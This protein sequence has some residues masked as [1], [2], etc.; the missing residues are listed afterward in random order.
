MLGRWG[1]PALRVRLPRARALTDARAG[2]AALGL[3]VTAVLAV[4]VFA[5]PRAAARSCPNSDHGFPAW[6]A[7]PLHLLVGGLRIAYNPLDIIFSALVVLMLPLYGVVVAAVRSLSL[8][9][10]AYTVV[11]LHLILLLSAP[12]QLNDV[13]NYL[14]YAR[15]GAV[16]G[17]NPY[18]H[19]IATI[20]HDP[21]YR[22]S[23]WHHLRSPYGWL[24]SAVTYPIALLPIPVA[25]WVLKVLAVGL[26]LVFVWLV[27]RCARLL[28][29]DP[30]FAVVLVA[31]NPIYLIYAVGGFHN[32][33]F[34]LVPMMAA[35][36]LMLERRDRSAGAML[37]LAVAVKFT[38]VLVLPFLLLGARPTRR[39][40]Q[41]L[42]GA[43][44]AAVPIARAHPGAVRAAPA[45]PP[46][47]EHAADQLQR[48]ERRRP[49][50]RRRW[51]GAVAAARGQRRG[52][53]RGRGAAAPP[54][55]LAHRRRVGDGG[56]DRQPGVADAVVRGVGAAAR[57]AA[58][59]RPAAPH[60]C[61]LHRVPRADVR[62]G[63][64]ACSRAASIQ[65]DGQ[66]RR[67][68]IA[69]PAGQARRVVRRAA[70]RF[71]AACHG[72]TLDRHREPRGVSTRSSSACCSPSGCCRCGWWRSICS[73]SWCTT[74]CGPAPTASTSSTRCST[75]RGSARTATHGLAANLFVLR[76][77][78]AD[79]FQPAVA[80]SGLLS[81]S[82]CR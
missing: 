14:G 40:K 27:A 66:L 77:T 72:P 68:G 80:I 47:S 42:L 65:P 12:L 15:L 53:R 4:V 2:Y 21:V 34:M 46:G 75:C 44:L 22:F 71:R 23:S 10:I 19:G 9:T 49:A 13:F 43:G 67:P 51:R 3:I 6:E 79:Y 50:D 38:A 76:P 59:Q 16:H 73:R 25:Y 41:L 32:D 20:L 45:E 78:P 8:R 81:A 5:S 37:A 17:L 60:R 11:A 24:F 36:A 55:Q 62:A 29:R 54:R 57:G 39:R 61:R 74:G 69:A 18:A 26:G 48:P 64:P 63:R 82:A 35:V 70:V 7:G 33:F 58:G 31:L 30:R 1:V 52:G 28:G 56:A